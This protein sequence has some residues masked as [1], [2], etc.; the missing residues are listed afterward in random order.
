M[1]VEGLSP[2]A[3][4][5]RF[6]LG[7]LMKEPAVLRE[8]QERVM[9]RDFEDL[10]LGSIYAG[11]C[12]MGADGEPIDYLSVYDHLASWD[13]RGLELGNLA[14]WERDVP[15]AAN[16]AYYANL[17]RE[18]A[19]GRAVREVALR[20]GDASDVGPAMQRAISD[21]IEIRDRDAVGAARVRMLR[22]VLDV[23][24]QEDVYDWVI[25]DVLERRDRLMLTGSEG[26]GK[27]T[28]LRQMAL[29]SAAGIHPFNF[30]DIQPTRVLVVDAENSERQWRRATRGMADTAAMQGRR[31]P[32]DFVAIETVKSIDI[33]RPADLAAIHRRMDEVVPDLL[34]IGPLYRLV[35]RAIQSDDDA[36]PV[37]AALD[38]LRDRDVAMLIE[39]HA[40]HAGSAQGER[41]LRPRGSS[42]LLGWP[43]FGLGLRREKAVH[44]GVVRFS[45]TRWRGDRDR[46]D[47]PTKFV[48]GQVWPWEPTFG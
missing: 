20:L 25:P 47:W 42:A 22:D 11:I 30:T 38:S 31:D 44:N 6:V 37:L 41:D 34:L 21:L 10:R 39:A 2:S 45:L 7:A 13:V 35:P 32:R 17:V 43:E 33:T 28:M 9:P 18:A 19:M 14:G 26:G 1:N 24:E 46:R 8:V 15:T 4:A 48:R 27:S 29:L 23:P 12:R 16:V 40:G 5:E 36:A 3:A